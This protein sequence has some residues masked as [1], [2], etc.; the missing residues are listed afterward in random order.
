MLLWMINKTAIQDCHFDDY[1]P[2]QADNRTDL[3]HVKP[4]GYPN[5]PACGYYPSTYVPRSTSSNKLLK[6]WTANN[7]K[8]TV[9]TADL[10]VPCAGWF[11]PCE[12]PIQKP[13]HADG[14]ADML[15]RMESMDVCMHACMTRT[16]PLNYS[17]MGKQ[18]DWM[19]SKRTTHCR[20]TSLS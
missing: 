3:C 17:I 1:Y 2:Y 19:N 9:R 12:S 13:S 20:I 14:C 6:I 8:G 4:A 10:W 15:F 11:K 18:L 16:A 7:C 5:H